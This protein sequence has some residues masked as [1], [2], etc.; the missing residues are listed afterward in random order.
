M[1]NRVLIGI[2][3][4][5]GPV[6]QVFPGDK[7]AAARTSEIH[8]SYNF[9]GSNATAGWFWLRGKPGA[10]NSGQGAF[11]TRGFLRMGPDSS[12]ILYLFLRLAFTIS[13]DS[14]LGFSARSPGGGKLYVMLE[15]RKTGRNI[16][17]KRFPLPANGSWKTIKVPFSHFKVPNGTG[18][19][20]IKF[21][22]MNKERQS[23][24]LDLDNVVV[25]SGTDFAPPGPVKTVTAGF[26]NQTV[27]LNWTPSY[28]TGGI[29]GYKVYRG[30]H[31]GFKCGG[32][33]LWGTAVTN[34]FTDDVFM[35]EATY[36][37]KVTI[38][39]FA[40]NETPGCKAAAV[41]VK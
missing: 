9:T 2:L 29:A 40:G 4:L 20:C 18:I 15:E 32:S 5:T 38:V 1:L 34:S 24:H 6:C 19:K 30:L 14:W 27:K 22:I 3:L 26:A 31:P 35:H 11:G 10:V 21:Y 37:Y 36:Y 12:R 28:P 13:P 23:V 16:A 25:G 41:E 33:T 7:T 17:T 39:D 8:G